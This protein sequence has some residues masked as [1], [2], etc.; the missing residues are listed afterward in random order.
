MAAQEAQATASLEWDKASAMHGCG[1]AARHR[2]GD[3]GRMV[4]R[5][6]AGHARLRAPL[7]CMCSG[8]GAMVG[9]FDGVTALALRCSSAPEKEMSK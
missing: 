8:D 5:H 1:G 7:V 6:R 9:A 3:L 4:A 2:G